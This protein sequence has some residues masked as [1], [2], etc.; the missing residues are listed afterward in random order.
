M[1]SRPIWSTTN[2][3][4]RETFEANAKFDMKL[5][6]KLHNLIDANHFE[7]ERASFLRVFISV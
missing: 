7:L 3:S 2:I 1:K 6:K 5:Q 4:T